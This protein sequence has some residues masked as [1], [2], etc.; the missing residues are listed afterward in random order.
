MKIAQKSYSFILST[1]GH[2]IAL[3]I[4]FSW[5]LSLVKNDLGENQIDVLSSYVYEEKISNLSL[6]EKKKMN[7]EMHQEEETEKL[8]V[9]KEPVSKQGIAISSLSQQKV[10]KNTT[11][12]RKQIDLSDALKKMKQ[13]EAHPQKALA[14]GSGK[15]IAEI[16]AMLHA[17]IKQQQQYPESALQMQREGRITI[18][19]ILFPDG[20]IQDLRTIKRSGTAS[21]DEAAIAAVH[22][23]VPF[24][25][26]YKYLS[27]PQ[28]YETVIGFEL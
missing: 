8:I 9:E 17:A 5:D 25:G 26:V 21:L 1:I 7:K 11:N 28:R 10:L 3:I 2:V 22:K 4:I 24:K 27:A 13:Q 19:F 20:T 16:V 15:P 14:K 12:N 6:I 23:A 18:T